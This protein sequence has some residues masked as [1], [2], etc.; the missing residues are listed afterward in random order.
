VR[1]HLEPLSASVDGVERERVRA[2]P[3]YPTRPSGDTLDLRSAPDLGAAAMT[4]RSDAEVSMPSPDTLPVHDQPTALEEL[5]A[6]IAHELRSPLAV[7]RT[8]AETAV[9]H[10]LDPA[11]LRVLLDVIRR[12]ADLALLLTDRLS[13]AR[14]V[15]RG[16]FHPTTVAL[17]LLELAQ[18]TVHDL[19][20]S[21]AGDH[22]VH[23]VGERPVAV[24]ADEAALREIL[25]NLLLNAGK[26]SPLGSDIEVAVTSD[27]SDATL[28]VRDQGDG[29]REQDRQRIFEKYEQLDR[30]AA[31]VGLGLFISRGLARANGGDLTVDSPTS[32]GASFVLRLPSAATGEEEA[33][34]RP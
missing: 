12:N 5:L 17:D 27:R 19:T 32:G 21:M 23:L 25:F 7:L 18:Q 2:N 24:L 9:I 33:P 10:D 29:V 15:E 22:R 20:P 31:G 14:D 8:A 11:Q 28:T 1:L 26:Y 16:E 6:V 13:L 3:R 4:A 34:A 30:T